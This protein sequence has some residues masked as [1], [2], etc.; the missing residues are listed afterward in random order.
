MKN[1]K[2][3]LTTLGLLSLPAILGS[4]IALS[5][6]YDQPSTQ[7][8]W[9]SIRNMSKTTYEQ[10]LDRYKKAGYR[11][12]D[13]ETDGS[14]WAVVFRKN[15]EKKGWAIHTMLEDS[16]FSS[17]WS[18]Y[19]SSGYRLLDFE[20]YI[21]SGKRFYGGIWVKNTSGKPWASNRNMTSSQFTEKFNQ[22]RSQGMMP[23][24]FESYTM[25]SSV[26][27]AAVWAHNTSGVQWTLNRDVSSSS[28]SSLMTQRHRSGYRPLDVELTKVGSTMK[29]GMIFVKDSIKTYRVT[30]VNSKDY[31]N[32]WRKYKDMGFRQA[33]IEVVKTPTLGTR[34]SGIFLENEKTMTN[35]SKKNT[36]DSLIRTYLNNEPAKGLTAAISING[37]TYFKRGYGVSNNSQNAHSGT[38]YRLASIS[39]AVT[40]T[41]GFLAEDKGYL[42]LNAPIRGYLPGLPSFHNY[43]TED[44]ITNRSMVRHYITSD[45]VSSAGTVANAWDATK[46]FMNSSL[47]G[48]NYNYSTHGYTIFAAALE[49]RTNR[50]FCS[51]L[52]TLLTSK[53]GLKSLKCE[54]RA[55]SNSSRS[56]LFSATDSGFSKRTPDSLSWKYAGG[57][58]EAHALDLLKFG[59][60]VYRNRILSASDTAKMTTRPDSAANYAYGWDTGSNDGNK[61]FAK[62]G[63]QRGSRTHLRIYPD[64]GIVIS[65]MSNTSGDNLPQLARDIAKELY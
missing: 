58:M 40:G 30:N 18:Q 46:L 65:L 29:Y 60:L 45:P 44:L 10:T 1:T 31:A 19:K 49:A 56:D 37:R 57:G 13:V 3:K 24:D 27:Y 5:N 12:V 63:G 36:V 17:K 59:N 4:T 62:S 32:A 42:N 7:K 22:Y 39:K 20:T 25:G 16:A 50:S 43:S 47:V 53:H 2:T 35:W 33:D 9:A 26:R 23:I 11:P 38:I 28:A 52:T 21:K 55:Q 61:V 15:T 64:N 51:N 41:L 14:K 48:G 6:G 34:Y 54:N 8:S